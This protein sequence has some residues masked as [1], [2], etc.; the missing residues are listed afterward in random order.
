MR[1]L[2]CLF[3][4]RITRFRSPRE[5]SSGHSDLAV[6]RKRTRRR[7]RHDFGRATH[8]VSRL[9]HRI[10][11]RRSSASQ[12][13]EGLRSGPNRD[14]RRNRKRRHKRRCGRRLQRLQSSQRRQRTFTNRL[15]NRHRSQHF[16]RFPGSQ[17]RKRT[18]AMARCQVE[19]KW[20]RPQAA[21]RRQPCVTTS[22]RLCRIRHRPKHN[23]FNP[24]Q[25]N[26]GINTWQQIEDSSIVLTGS[27]LA[28]ANVPF[29]MSV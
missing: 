28:R 16:S 3:C 11:H 1:R 23:L 5:R 25:V 2:R 24:L 14:R 19:G 13:R 29:T 4:A 9:N 20:T 21:Q 7:S 10:R 27:Q 22:L 12:R 6:G 8:S 17:R 26:R 18:A 15:G